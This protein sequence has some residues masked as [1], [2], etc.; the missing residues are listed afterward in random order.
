[1]GSPFPV[2]VVWPKEIVAARTKAKEKIRVFIVDKFIY[3]DLMTLLLN[4]NYALANIKITFCITKL[5]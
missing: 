5:S 1:V 4:T 3:N 2:V